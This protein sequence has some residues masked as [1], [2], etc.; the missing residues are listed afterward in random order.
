MSKLIEQVAKELI[1]KRGL[2]EFNA[3]DLTIIH[4]IYDECVKRGMKPCKDTGK[5]AHPIDVRNKIVK[6]MKSGYLFNYGWFP[7]SILKKMSWFELKE[8]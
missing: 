4:E 6:G 1:T 8:K 5:G 2:T 7:E 3:G